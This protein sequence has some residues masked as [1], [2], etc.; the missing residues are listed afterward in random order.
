MHAEPAPV[1]PGRGVH[2]VGSYLE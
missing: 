1:L 2:V